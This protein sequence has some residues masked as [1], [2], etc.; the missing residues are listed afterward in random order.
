M[1]SINQ[2]GRAALVAASVSSV[3][4]RN[5]TQYRGGNLLLIAIVLLVMLGIISFFVL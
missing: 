4:S 1:E 3:Q 2:A 5:I